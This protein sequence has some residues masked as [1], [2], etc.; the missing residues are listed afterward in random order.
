[1]HGHKPIHKAW[2]TSKGP[3]PLKWRF[4]PPE[5]SSVTS[6][7]ARGGSL[8]APPYSMLES[9]PTCPCAGTRSCYEFRDALV[10]MTLNGLVLPDPWPLQC[11]HSLFHGV[12]RAWRREK[13]R[14]RG[15]IMA[16]RYTD[17]SSLHSDQ[18]L[19]LCMNPRH[20]GA[21]VNWLIQSKR[22]H[23]CDRRRLR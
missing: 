21:S 6:S 18:P 15:P 17:T 16:P 11:F 7:L 1:M 12:S 2:L 13:M 10:Q 5:P 20:R 19:S 9:W 8:T 3:H 4:P 23:R 14:Y 22:D